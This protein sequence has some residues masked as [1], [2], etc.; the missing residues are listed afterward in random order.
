MEEENKMTTV[1]KQQ[2]STNKLINIKKRT[3]KSLTENQKKKF[4]HAKPLYVDVN[5]AKS[6]GK[7]ERQA[8]PVPYSDLY[9]EQFEAI[10]RIFNLKE[11]AVKR[12][13]EIDKS[14]NNGGYNSYSYS[15]RNKEYIISYG[16]LSIPPILGLENS[17]IIKYFENNQSNLLPFLVNQLGSGW[18]QPFAQNVNDWA[19]KQILG[20]INNKSFHDIF[21]HLF[22]MLR[23]ERLGWVEEPFF[24]TLALNEFLN[25]SEKDDLTLSEYTGNNFDYIYNMLMS[26]DYPTYYHTVEL[27]SKLTPKKSNYYSYEYPTFIYTSKTPKID[28][29]A[30]QSLTKNQILYAIENEDK[31]TSHTFS[32]LASV[33]NAISNKGNELEVSYYDLQKLTLKV[34]SEALMKG[35]F[36]DSFRSVLDLMVIVG[37]VVNSMLPQT[38]QEKTKSTKNSI[39]YKR[40]YSLIKYADNNSDLLTSKQVIGFIVSFHSHYRKLAVNSATLEDYV[41]LLENVVEEKEEESAVRFFALIGDLVISKYNAPTIIEWTDYV[42]GDDDFITPLS[43]VIN[44]ITDGENRKISNPNDFHY[45]YDAF[46]G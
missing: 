9:V 12:L 36:E 2:N 24:Q 33:Q 46:N 25:H 4:E 38:A 29:E 21:E 37:N 34:I 7:K 17:E 30:I 31:L 5:N 15:N 13:A 20:K 43:F 39:Y 27:F 14:R 44:L 18:L 23:E 10:D 16:D 28:R 40:I 32:V 11:I 26:Y 1:K 42:T 19:K 6:D 35:D 41:A 3:F 8:D 22:T 45:I